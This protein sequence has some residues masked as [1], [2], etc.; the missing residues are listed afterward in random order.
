MRRKK[1][2]QQVFST[3]MMPYLV[4]IRKDPV[5]RHLD[6][7]DALVEWLGS[8]A[9]FTHFSGQKRRAIS[10]I[11]HLCKHEEHSTICHH[12]D[13]RHKLFI[14]C[15]GKVV[16]RSPSLGHLGWLEVGDSAGHVESHPTME[17]LAARVEDRKK[18]DYDVELIAASKLVMVAVIKRAE[19]R[20]VM[21]SFREREQWRCA[22]FLG[23]HV[24][25]TRE[26]SK[27]R[28][29]AFARCAETW[30]VE[31]GEII[32]RQGERCDY[33]FFVTEG[34]C[35]VQKRIQFS[36][37]NTMPT[38]SKGKNETLTMN[39]S[40]VVEVWV[41]SAGD[42]FG[43]AAFIADLDGYENERDATVVARVPSQLLAI[44]EK[45]FWELFATG[46]ALDMLR[47]HV[48]HFK[49]QEEVL[50]EF[51]E[52]ARKK[53]VWEKANTIVEDSGPGKKSLMMDYEEAVP[54]PM[55]ITVEG[56]HFRSSQKLM[57]EHFDIWTTVAAKRR[58]Q[59]KIRQR[60]RNAAKA[61][62]LLQKLSMRRHTTDASTSF[63]DLFSPTG[64]GDGTGKQQ[65][66]KM[67]A[68]E[69]IAG[70][71]AAKMR[72]QGGAPPSRGSAVN[73]PPSGQQSALLSAGSKLMRRNS[74]P[75][76]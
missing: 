76:L 16:V 40:T 69:M 50:A 53:Q 56:Q 63:S 72:L 59:N 18:R 27:S 37:T 61:S 58:L 64:S 43:H 36:K 6:D 39:T 60:L 11:T 25:V 24:D 48:A 26:W 44:K 33:M 35:A 47:L 21:K 67:T 34:S 66:P 31:K 65:Q 7:K 20:E 29:I 28:R 73:T 57:G 74:M 71:A 12:G 42:Y 68:L 62:N 5:D 2:F 17:K 49:T 3:P 13:S 55:G 70:A 32:I 14:V 52:H 9:L 41:A 19:Y 8:H 15:Q 4:A 1:D 51:N 46:N 38:A 30:N 45:H 22:N 23:R 10:Q 75:T 54:R